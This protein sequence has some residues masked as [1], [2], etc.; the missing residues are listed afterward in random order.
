MIQHENNAAA[1]AILKSAADR[2]CLWGPS[3]NGK[4]YLARELGRPGDVIVDYG[5]SDVTEYQMVELLDDADGRVIVLLPAR[6]AVMQF[7][8]KTRTRLSRCATAEVGV[9]PREALADL[10]RTL[11]RGLV[12]THAT[13][14]ATCGRT[15]A[16]IEGFATAWAAMADWTPGQRVE[17]LT[18][19]PL[20]RTRTQPGDVL[21]AVCEFYKVVP[22]E[23]TGQ[24]RTVHVTLPRHVSMYLMRQLCRMTF[25]EIGEFMG[26]RDHSTTM[27]ACNKITGLVMKDPVIRAEVE[28]CVASIGMLPVGAD[29]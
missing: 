6:P 19:Q 18:K 27:H 1:I 21:R 9:W 3:G 20:E 2:V 22:R 14:F 28:Q 25:V 8:D 15:P 17:M 4:S 5:V 29:Q 23:V 13:I 11:M 24:R 26:N 10:A 16:A 12:P 7:A